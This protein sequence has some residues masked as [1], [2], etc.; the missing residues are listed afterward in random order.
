MS[1]VRDWLKLEGNIVSPHNQHPSRPVLG[2]NCTRSEVSGRRFWALAKE[3]SKNDP[4]VFFKN[5]FVYNYYPLGL[6]TKTAKNLTPSDLKVRFKLYCFSFI[7]YILEAV[8][9]LSHACYS[10]VLLFKKLPPF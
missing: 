9:F 3:I 10:N 4:T 8:S 6:L 7:D 2:F 1:V 5:S